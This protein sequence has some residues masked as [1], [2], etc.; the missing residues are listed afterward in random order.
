MVLMLLGFFALAAPVLSR[1]SAAPQEKVAEKLVGAWRLVS[2]Q[3]DSPMRKV[4]YDH[5]TQS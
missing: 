3:G 1:P 2:E 4:G 5:P